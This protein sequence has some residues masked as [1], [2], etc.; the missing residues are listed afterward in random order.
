MIARLYRLI[1]GSDI[2]EDVP[3]GLVDAKQSCD[4]AWRDQG[5][6]FRQEEDQQS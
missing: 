2:A 3:S 1:G 4:E 5:R 6:A